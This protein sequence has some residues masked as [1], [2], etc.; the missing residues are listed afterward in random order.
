MTPKAPFFQSARLVKWPD[1][2]WVPVTGQR[3]VTQQ[4]FESQSGLTENIPDHVL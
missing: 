1:A 4:G 3:N 2:G